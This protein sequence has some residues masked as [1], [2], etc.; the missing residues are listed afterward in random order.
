MDKLIMHL[1]SLGMKQFPAQILKDLKFAIAGE[2]HGAL[3]DTPGSQIMKEYAVCAANL[4]MLNLS[5]F[6]GML[7]SH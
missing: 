7:L 2:K 6:D 3:K 4:S 1:S 5:T